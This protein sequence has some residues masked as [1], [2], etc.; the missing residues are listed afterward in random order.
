M[1][2]SLLDIHLL[3]MS[4]THYI[5]RVDDG[6]NFRSS[7]LPFWGVKRGGMNK[8]TGKRGNGIKT[9]VEKFK[10][11][12][13]LWFLTSKT[14]GGKLIAMAEYTEF[15]DKDDEPL[16]SI[17][18][19]TNSDQNWKGDEEWS[20]QIHYKNLYITEKQNIL[21]VLQC[22]GTIIEYTQLN[23]DGSPSMFARLGSNCPDLHTHYKNYKFYN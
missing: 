14:H 22:G 1:N 23:K 16:V 3:I 13:I 17:K 19:Y 7:R 10:P 11:G 12:D 15:F 21:M 8:R 5:I 18:T 2:I 9:I 20:I 4:Q 6:E